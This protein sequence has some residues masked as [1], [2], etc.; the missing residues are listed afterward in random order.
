MAEKAPVSERRTLAAPRQP[1]RARRL[2]IGDRGRK[3]PAIMGRPMARYELH[4]GLE[5]CERE[6]KRSAAIAVG[7]GRRASV[8]GGF[9]R[10]SA[11]SKL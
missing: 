10:T 9:D 6:M 8:A 2:G 7:R 11:G 1:S 4:T 3:M 5:R